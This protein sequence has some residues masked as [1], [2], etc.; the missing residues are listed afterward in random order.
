[1]PIYT[2]KRE[3]TNQIVEIYQS[4]NDI[5]EYKGKNGD[6]NDWIRIYD[7]PQAS[8]DTKQNPFS[9]NS[10]LDTTKNKKGTYGDLLDYSRELSD[11]RASLSGGVDPI[12][13]KYYENYSKQRRGA[14]HPD[15]IQKTFETKNV[16]VDL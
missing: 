11:K 3:S 6:Q 5:H 9:Q 4:M 15:K 8:F 13:E 2:F 14:K 16:R 7:I 1:M 10:F 12:K